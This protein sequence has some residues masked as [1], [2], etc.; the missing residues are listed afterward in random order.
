M[1]Y[2]IHHTPGSFI[3]EKTYSLVWHYRKCDPD[4]AETR[5]SELAATLLGLTNNLNI[6]ILEGNKV[7]EIKKRQNSRG[8]S[9]HFSISE[10][11]SIKNHTLIK[12]RYCEPDES[13]DT[14]K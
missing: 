4:F 6:G 1:K 5:L 12:L 14:I 3:E 10:V 11:K 13:S 9:S 8:R 2:F 7:I